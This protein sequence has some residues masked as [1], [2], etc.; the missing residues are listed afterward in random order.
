[1]NGNGRV[2]AKGWVTDKHYSPVI[3]RFFPRGSPPPPPWRLS[4]GASFTGDSR[5]YHRQSGQS[6]V[7]GEQTMASEP[8][9]ELLK[10]IPPITELLKT[11][12]A[13]RWLKTHPLPLV[14]DCLRGA[15]STVREGLLA[16]SP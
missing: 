11:Q 9:Q 12:T 8:K 5:E 4:P 14:T 2:A 3:E 15:T 7:E 13:V 10:R 1:M 16:A 6:V